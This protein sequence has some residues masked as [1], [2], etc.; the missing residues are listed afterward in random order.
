MKTLTMYFVDVPKPALWLGILG[1]IP[2]IL[3]SFIAVGVD[4][5]LRSEVLFALVAYGAVILSFLGGVHWGCFIIRK[6][7]NSNQSD[8]IT[9]VICIVSTTIGW[10]SLI[11]ES[12]VVLVLLIISFIGMLRIDIRAVTAGKFPPWYRKLRWPLSVIVVLT[13]CLPLVYLR[14]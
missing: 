10:L 14:S 3:L 8:W 13:L 4:G 6:T 11:P 1:L 7:E 5:L 12:R 9:F 2:F